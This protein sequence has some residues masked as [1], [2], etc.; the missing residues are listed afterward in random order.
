MA[1]MYDELIK[2]K[3]A[4][5]KTKLALETDFLRM[6]LNETKSLIF[7]KDEQ[8]R[9]IY[10][11]DAFLGLYPPENRQ[12]IIGTT[13]LEEFP[14]SEVEGFLKEDRRALQ[15]EETEIIEQVT[16]YAGNTRTYLTRKLG[17][18]DKDGA[19][20]ML[21]ICYDVAKMV[22]QEKLLAE[23][24]IAL[25]K[26]TTIAAH[27]L[28]SPLNTLISYMDIIKQD[29]ETTLS[30]TSLDNLNDMR[31]SAL[32]MMNQIISLVDLFKDK[33]S[34]EKKCALNEIM[35]EVRYNLSDLI[36]TENAKILTGEMPIVLGQPDLFRQLFQNLVENSLKHKSDKLP[37]ITIKSIE[38]TDDFIFEI[39]DNGHG[40][41]TQNDPFILHDQ[42]TAPQRTGIGLTLCKRIVQSFGGKIWVDHSYN[43]GC[44]ICFSYPKHQTHKTQQA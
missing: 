17:F 10:A 6:A 25:E 38:N 1:L 7:V 11:N 34:T 39:E 40:I 13:T 24:N 12:N 28:R 19:P 30:Q 27:D 36:K 20:L 23:Q 9:I 16:D 31:K 15:G 26:F 42:N 32:L 8:F 18:T 2:N 14:E 37:L 41:S 21:G 3:I 33:K 5:P 22:E 35:A 4:M 44:K 29:K 43:E